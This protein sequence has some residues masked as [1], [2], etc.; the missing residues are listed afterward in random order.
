MALQ[1]MLPVLRRPHTSPRLLPTICLLALSLFS[2]GTPAATEP[3]NP[4]CEPYGETGQAVRKLRLSHPRDAIRIGSPFITSDA[5]TLARSV[6]AFDMAYAYG[7]IGEF[8]PAMA[9]VEQF[10]PVLQGVGHQPCLAHAYGAIGAIQLNAE[11]YEDALKWTELGLALRQQLGVEERIAGSLNNIGLI[12]L[13]LGQIELAQQYFELAFNK[14]RAEIRP[15]KAALAES[16][17]GYAD[18]KAGR[19][20]SALQRQQS[21][22]PVFEAENEFYSIAEARNF[23]G[24]ALLGLNQPTRAR[25]EIEAALA[26]AQQQQLGPL[27]SEITL[28]LARVLLHQRNVPD[29]ERL[30]TTHLDR[31]AGSGRVRAQYE[32]LE[33]LTAILEQQQRYPEALATFRQ[34]HD[35]GQQLYNRTMAVKLV[36]ARLNYV[37]RDQE[38]EIGALKLSNELTSVA[39]SRQKYLMVSWTIGLVA[40][41]LLLLLVLMWRNHRRELRQQQQ[42]NT[43]LAELD[44]AKDTVLSNTSHELRTPL[45]GIIGLSEL[46]LQH[47]SNDEIRAYASMILAS[48]RQLSGVVDDLLLF[49]QLKKAQPHLVL[50]PINLQDC[51]VSAIENSKPLLANKSVHVVN[52]LLPDLPAVLA[53]P[54]RVQ[55]V[56]GHLL[57]NAIKFTEHGVIRVRA[58]VS[59]AMMH[60]AV[61]DTGIGITP[62]DQRRIFASFEQVEASTVRR[63]QGL[64]LG[65]AICKQLVNLHGGD[66]G[67]ES[68]PGQGSTFWFTLP[69]AALPVMADT[70]ASHHDNDRGLGK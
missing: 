8:E 40:T 62:A 23:A 38:R 11:D 18:L 30:L 47:E 60:I 21:A 31:L 20:E 33:L 66:I 4:S 41:A 53:D 54:V 24:Q 14:W 59:G 26:M 52:E 32:T 17:M 25:I 61:S 65:L 46:I 19:F 45:N 48:G 13:Y 70:P 50:R 10:L 39:L 69:L 16:N 56:L 37:V 22:L 12:Y 42:L 2:I 34:H 49:S 43:Q 1:R 44:R 58:G 6:V 67:V 29:A 9:L 64:G 3:D 51:V 15:L 35:L 28:A 63:F 7:E 55:Q 5:A 36:S 27:E 57:G 68:V